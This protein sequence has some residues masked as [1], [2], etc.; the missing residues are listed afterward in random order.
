MRVHV[1]NVH[2]ANISKAHYGNVEN[3]EDFLC[4]ICESSFKY[5]KNLN[6]HIRSKHETTSNDA[7]KV[8]CDICSLSFTEEKCLHAHKKL[9]HTLNI[10]T[11]PCSVCGKTFNQEWNMK[12]HLRIHDKE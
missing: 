10:E 11:F 8:Q 4:D 1:L 12:R 7:R 2:G 5:K 9:K 6:H 3:Q